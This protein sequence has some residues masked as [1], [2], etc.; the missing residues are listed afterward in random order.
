MIDVKPFWKKTEA[1][2]FVG[3]TTGIAAITEQVLHMAPDLLP[4]QYKML[5]V[6]VLGL[7]GSSLMAYVLKLRHDAYANAGLPDPG[8]SSGLPAAPALVAK[9]GPP[10]SP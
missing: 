6:S 4:P 2:L 9:K 8:D 5:A 1:Y 10:N 3:V 7:C